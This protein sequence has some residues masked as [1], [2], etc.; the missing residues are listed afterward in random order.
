[1]SGVANVSDALY[2]ATQLVYAATDVL[3]VALI[4]TVIGGA[5]FV[6]CEVVA[7]TA[8]ARVVPDDALGRVLGVMQGV[9]VAMMLAGAALAPV[10]IDVTSL[11]VSFV[12]LGVTALVVALGSRAALG[13]LDA[14]SRERAEFLGSRVAVIDKLPVVAGVP[15]LALERLVASLRAARKLA[16]EV[17]RD[18]PVVQRAG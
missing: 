1:M 13:G 18:P 15:R 11:S 7:E 12:V 3:A 6:A 16:A 5:G 10:L 2:C 17:L 4:G 8:L 14:L 9:S